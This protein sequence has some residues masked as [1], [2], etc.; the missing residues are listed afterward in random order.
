M[1]HVKI[2][3]QGI[4]EFKR[5]INKLSKD[6]LKS[7]KNS[8][9]EAGFFVEAEVVAS[10]AGQRA[11]PR[12]V[13]TGRFMGSVKTTFP[14]DMMAQVASDVEYAKHLEYGTSRMLP[15]KHFHNTA[16]RNQKKVSEFVLKSIK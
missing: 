7:F 4:K 14:N 5:F 3:V 12:S 13:D 6:K 10:I 1:S 9:K 15:R 11:E 16:T 8:I 2:E